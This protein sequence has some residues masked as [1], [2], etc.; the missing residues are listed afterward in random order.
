METEK[1]PSSLSSL[2]IQLLSVGWTACA[3]GTIV[4]GMRIYVNV[5]MAR[6]WDA[7]FWFSLATYVS[8]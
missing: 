8:P 4:F 5:A 6:K 1:A 7:A 2:G 3:I